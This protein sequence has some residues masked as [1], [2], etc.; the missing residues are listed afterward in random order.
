[1]LS[2]NKDDR[3]KLRS[4]G[5]LLTRGFLDCNIDAHYKLHMSFMENSKKNK[6]TLTVILLDEPDWPPFYNSTCETQVYGGLPIAQNVYYLVD[7]LLGKNS[8]LAPFVNFPSLILEADTDGR[9]GIDIFFDAFDP[10]RFLCDFIVTFSQQEGPPIKPT[11]K[12]YYGRVRNIDS[13]LCDSKTDIF[14]I[15][16]WVRAIFWK[17][18]VAR[19][20]SQCAN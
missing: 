6:A 1:M 14:S 12:F 9:C 7:V 4:K 20:N 19:G 10:F 5:I 18:A 17:H 11:V 8:I 3:F 13:K 15:S 2:G 16:V